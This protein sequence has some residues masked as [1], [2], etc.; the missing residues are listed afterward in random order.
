MNATGTRIYNALIKTHHITS[1]KKVSKLKKE[2]HDKTHYVLI[3][4][5]GSPGLMY[6]EGEEK[7]VRDWVNA[8]QALR[9]KDYQL[10]RRPTALPDQAI[11]RRCEGRGGF[12]EEESV[13]GFAA[14]LEDRGLLSWW[15]HAMGYAG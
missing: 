2:A 12:D 13:R 1:R 15:R 5:G 9:Y 14:R 3:R 11:G 7:G 4:A 6:V 10:V 8:V